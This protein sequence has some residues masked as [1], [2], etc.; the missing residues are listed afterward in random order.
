MGAVWSALLVGGGLAGALILWLLRGDSGAPGKDGGAEPLKDAPPGEAAAPGGGPG[1]GGSGGLSPEPSDRELVSKAEHLRESNGHLISESKDLGNLTEAQRLQN[2]GNAREYV[3]V[4]KVPDTHSRANSETSRN[5]SPESRVGEWRLPKGHET[6][7]K[8]AGSVAEKLPSSSPL[9]DR[10]E[11]ASLAQS[12]GHE[13]WEVVSRHSSW[14]SVGLGGSLEASR[15]SLNQGMD[16]SRNSLVGGGWEVDG[17]VV[18]VKPRQVSIQFKVHYSTSTDVQFIAVT[19]DHE[20]LGGWNTYIP[21]HYCKDGLWSHSV[22]LPA[23]TVVEW[24]F[25]L[26]ENKEVTR[27]EE[28]SNRRLQTG[29][30]DKVVHGW[31]GIH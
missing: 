9:M 16:E 14:G 30:E 23:D 17:K 6:A 10:A 22:F 31:W 5:Q 2:V 4:G 15:L 28:C 11:A 20:S 8:V 21:L 18:S 13:D 19:G 3:P 27:W 12:A 1:G 29:H 25:V 26:V 7:V 24:K